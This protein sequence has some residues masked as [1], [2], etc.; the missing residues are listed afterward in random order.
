[1]Q[2]SQLLYSSANEN[3][4]LFH[5]TA[6]WVVAQMA[7]NGFNPSQK[8]RNKEKETDNVVRFLKSN[9]L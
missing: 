7:L 8:E 9:H 2:F 6:K 3:F 4:L 1:V 5:G